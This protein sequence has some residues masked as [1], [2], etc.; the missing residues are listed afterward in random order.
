MP[1][2]SDLG[3]F[4]DNRTTQGLDGVEHSMAYR[5]HENERHNHGYRRWFCAANA[6][7]GTHFADNMLVA[8]AVPACV[9][10]QI[11]AGNNAWGAWVQLLGSADTPVIAG[12]AYFDPNELLFTAVERVGSI[13]VVQI[14]YG[15]SGGAAITAEAYTDFVLIPDLGAPKEIPR[16]AGFERAVAGSLMWARCWCPGQNTATLDFMFG[17][18]EYPG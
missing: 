9:S 3:A 15:A 4:L 1:N 5:V 2:M 12:S 18:H 6:P 11:D 14:G 7:T 16:Q 13:Y 10:F 8:E 17:M